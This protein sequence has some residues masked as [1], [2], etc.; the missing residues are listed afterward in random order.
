MMSTVENNREATL[1]FFDALQTGDG[2]RIA[3]FY[4]E[5]GR[6]VTM[7]NTLISGVRSKSDIRQ[8]AGGVLEAFPAGLIFSV[9]TL[10]AEENRVAVEASS[11]GVHVSGASYQNHYHFLFTWRDGKLVELKEY[12]DTEVITDVLCGGARPERV[13]AAVGA[14]NE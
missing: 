1:A 7:G 10:T 6:V 11:R 14:S 8:F 3:G 12:M 5:D 9:H 2:E 13:A 4:A